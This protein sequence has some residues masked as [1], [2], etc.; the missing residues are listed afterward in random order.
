MKHKYWGKP[1][2]FFAHWKKF[3]EKKNQQNIWVIIPPY[4]WLMLFFF[5]PFLL[6]LK[7]S[8]AK[9]SINLP[10]FTPLFQWVEQF[11]LQINLNFSNYITIFSDNFYIRA[12]FSSFWIAAFSTLM[13]LILG[14]MMAYGI[15]RAKKEW[16]TVLLLLVALPFWTSFLIRVYAWMSLLSTKG[17]INELL[18]KLGII[19]TPI[20]LLD[21][22]IAVCVGIVYCYL[23]FMVLPIYAV[24][25][26]IDAS[27]IEAAFDLGCSPWQAFWRITVPLSIPG[28]ISGCFLV[29]LPAI[30][31]FVIP[32]LLGGPNTV[33]IGRALWW[34]FF[35]NRDWP[36]ASAIAVLM[37]ILFVV[38]IMVMQSRQLK[39]HLKK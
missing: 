36:M 3:F 12:L 16:Q 4:F 29:F 7:I 20:H 13:C 18:L 25:Q 22:P 35:N 26:K 34:E 19:Q 27:F 33:T 5:V 8:F 14:Y 6:I 1:F 10:P 38:P 30:G 15:N 21:N 37:V 2:S 24:L 32:E 9:T 11:A 28:I 23:P 17:I 39:H 31:E